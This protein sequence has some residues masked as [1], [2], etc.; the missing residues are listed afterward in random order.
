MASVA[1]LGLC[2]ECRSADF[3]AQSR[4]QAGIA[5]HEPVRA[6]SRADALTARAADALAAA[7]R[8]RSLDLSPPQLKADANDASNIPFPERPHMGA[9]HA[10]TAS[11]APEF[12]FQGSR[13]QE[14][15]Q[16]F[17]REGLPVAR[18][19]ETHSALLS[20]GLNQRGKPGLWLI[21]K[22]H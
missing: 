16:R 13:A 9:P 4:P 19:W 20:L 6:P 22:T 10:A 11:E 17:H 1:L 12:H 7:T 21:Q 2:P 8:R 5:G 3:F 14:M 15:A 18:L